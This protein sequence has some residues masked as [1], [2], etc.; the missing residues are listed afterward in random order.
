M[1][2]HR[3]LTQSG[4]AFPMSLLCQHEGRW[5]KVDSDVGWV[6]F[7]GSCFRLPYGFLVRSHTHPYASIRIAPYGS[8]RV[9]TYPF[10]PIHI[11]THPYGRELGLL[12][13]MLGFRA[14]YP[15]SR[16][17]GFLCSQTV[18]VLHTVHR[19]PV[20]VS[21]IVGFLQLY[22][23]TV[24]LGFGCNFQSRARWWTFIRVERIYGSRETRSTTRGVRTTTTARAM[25]PASI[26]NPGC[27]F[28]FRV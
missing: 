12:S 6:S 19:E 9:H 21:A 13:L 16:V 23:M 27:S 7:Q 10:A 8:I 4:G 18:I 26:S 25:G 5:L 20:T 17:W 28:G 14:Y 15:E 3:P 2:Q 24:N 11:H 1:W 22:G